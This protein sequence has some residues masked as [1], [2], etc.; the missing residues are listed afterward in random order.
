[1]AEL[2]RY[3]RGWRGY[4]GF[5]ETPSVLRHLNSW[6][7][8]RIRSAYWRQWKT[9]RKR[10]AE[11]VRRGVSVE[12]AQ[13]AGSRCEPWCT[14]QSPALVWEGRRSDPSP[15]PDLECLR[16]ESDPQSYLG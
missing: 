4:F 8:R 1:M 2:A 11:P 12:A 3:L 5:C 14:S 7:R 16:H 15:Y 13:S 6:I 9:G 10:Y